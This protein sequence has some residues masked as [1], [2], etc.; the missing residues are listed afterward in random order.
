LQLQRLYSTFP[1]GSPGYGL[2]ILRIALGITALFRGALQLSESGDSV[3]LNWI[4]GFFVIAAAIFLLVGFL[5][6]VTGLIIFAGGL[7]SLASN[8][9]LSIAIYTLVLAAAIVFLGPG[10]FSLDARLFGRREIV[11]PKNPTAAND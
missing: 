8:Q 11:I 6:P 2:L 1:G 3:F 5:T 7:L 9:D 4:F 10:A